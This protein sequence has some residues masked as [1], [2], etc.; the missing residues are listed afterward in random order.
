MEEKTDLSLEYFGT[1]PEYNPPGHEVEALGGEV[2]TYEEKATQDNEFTPLPTLEADDRRKEK[3]QA[4]VNKR[5]HGLLLQAASILVAVVVVT[6]S[7]GVDLLGDSL[8]TETLTEFLSLAGAQSGVITVS[9]LWQT[10]DDMD[11]HVVT[12][13]GA[14]IYYGN[15]EA[16]GGK[17]DVDM[18]VSSFV[19][20]PV[21]NIFFETA[22][23]GIYKA[24]VH[25]FSNRTDGETEV[26]I[27][28]Q[29][30]GRTYQHRVSL[31]GGSSEAFEFVY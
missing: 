17:L 26:L 18:Q 20:N 29:V 25:E 2:Y 31:N 1:L 10:H 28:I 7:F 16:D 3:K 11:L 8:T 6:S 27:R 23:H 14:E 15:R 12:P 13:S 22:E 4:A 9:M 21:E 19:E 5:K 24:F 30:H